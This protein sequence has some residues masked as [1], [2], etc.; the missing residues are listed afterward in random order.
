MNNHNLSF[1]DTYIIR[2]FEGH[3]LRAYPDP[4]T[5][6]D[7]WTISYGLTG[8]WVKPGLTLTQ[9]QS[10]QEFMKYINKFCEDINKVLTVSLTKNQYL[11]VLSLVWNIGISRFKTSTLLKLINLKDYNSASNEFV[12][13]CKVNGKVIDGLLK[14]RNS[15]KALFVQPEIKE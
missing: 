10:D 4:I 14:R 1:E 5:K 8:E 11:A 2:K 7:P 6:A 13:W 15:E 12:K 3:S 9:Q